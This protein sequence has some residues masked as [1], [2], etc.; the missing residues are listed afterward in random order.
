[1][2]RL[3]A[4]GISAILLVAVAPHAVDAW[5]ERERDRR[6]EQEL[7]EHQRFIEAKDRE[8]ACFERLKAGGIRDGM[9]VKAEIERCR[10]TAAQH[11][12]G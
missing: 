6:L 8:I 3:L 12:G 4:G 10:R 5:R 9:N 11:Q 1:M 2:N 7:I